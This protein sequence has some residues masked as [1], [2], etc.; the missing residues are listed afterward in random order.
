L[1]NDNVDA[2]AQSA[3][4]TPAGE[5]PLHWK[6]KVWQV[7][8]DSNVRLAIWILALSEAAIAI[9]EIWFWIYYRR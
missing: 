7:F 4:F 2:E 8:A 9:K 6:T 3:K 5:L 1:S